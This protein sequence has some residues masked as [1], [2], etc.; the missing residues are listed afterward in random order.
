MVMNAFIYQC[1]DHLEEKIFQLLFICKVLQN[2]NI[3][4]VVIE[5]HTNETLLNI[6]KQYLNRLKMLNSNMQVEFFL[7]G[8]N[9]EDIS[10]DKK[11]VS[12]LSNKDQVF[13]NARISKSN[14]NDTDVFSQNNSQMSLIGNVNQFKLESGLNEEAENCL[15]SVYM[16]NY[17]DL[18]KSLFDYADLGLKLNYKPIYLNSLE[19]LKLIPIDNSRS[20]SL[21]KLCKLDKNNPDVNF[22]KELLF[23]KESP[24]KLCYT[25]GVIYS[26]LM[27]AN[28]PLSEE[29]LEFQVNFI[30]SDVAFEVQQFITTKDFLD[31][32][33]DLTKV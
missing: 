3:E 4:D 21:I 31:K 26:T 16:S 27:P 8:E 13:L 29:A 6:K 11:L 2:R 15:P 25:L 33:D 30:K 28:N 14:Y 1:Y 32:A 17:T 10:R 23:S 22:H 24:T 12:H 5:T 9:L 20:K 18:Y 7:N 19:I